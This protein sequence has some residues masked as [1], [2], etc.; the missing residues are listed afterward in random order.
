MRKSHRIAVSGALAAAFALAATPARG[1]TVSGTVVAPGGLPAAGARV[2]A[3]TAE[4][5]AETTTGRDGT[6]RLEIAGPP[7]LTIRVEAAGYPPAGKTVAEAE[8]S[9]LTIALSRPTV[10]E[11]ITV[12]A[13]R[14]P[15]PVADTAAP[16]TIVPREDLENTP[17]PAL[18][19][20]LRQVPGFSL[21]RRS[22]SRT[23]NPTSQG[24]S[25]RGLGASGTSRALV[26][27]DDIPM[28][29]P[30]G[31][32]VYWGRLPEIGLD[33]VEV[34]EGGGSDLWGSAALGGVIRLVRRD[35]AAPAVRAEAWGGSPSSADGSLRVAGAMGPLR[36]SA[37]AEVFAT[38]GYVAVAPEERGP[39]DVRAGS[40]HR[41]FEATAEATALG[42]SRLFVRASRYLEDR[43]N[44]TRLQRNDTEMTQWSGGF[45]GAAAGGA[46]ALRGY[47]SDERFHQTFSAISADRTSETRTSRQ[48]V[49][50][51]ATGGSAQWAR[52]I[53]T[54][55]ELV[56]GADFRE[57]EGTSEDTAFLPAGPALR[58]SGGRQRSGGAW[59]E[60]VAA[61][62]PRLTATA[63]LR[64]DAWSNLSGRTFEGGAPLALPDRSARSWSP[65]ASVVWAATRS[66]SLTAAG[67]RAFR[68][69]TLNELYRPFRLGNVQTLANADLAPE[70]V[71][72]VEAGA[73]WQ[74]L[75]GRLFA[76]ANLF[77][78]E[79]H[80]AVGNVTLAT[81][82][83]LITRRRENVGRVRDRGA[84]LAAD[85]R[86]SSAWSVSAGYLLAD[87][88]VAS[89]TTNPSLVGKRVP[90]VPRDQATLRVR[91][92]RPSLA[93]IVLQA[94]W[95]GRQYDDDAN[96]FRLGTAFT[97]DA[98]VSRELFG[99]G[100]IFAAVENLTDRRNEI[101]RTPVLTLGSPRTFRAGLRWRI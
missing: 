79:L 7:P 89:S 61:L 47:R 67:Y 90:Q 5:A 26:L 97:L 23:A 29:D 48:A 82:P 92:A 84:E 21:F 77:W 50:S 12:T 65:R 95:S 43:S 31:G 76:R 101:G 91:F 94:R 51:S 71:T 44:G 41:A 85:A 14:T 70:T 28:N 81:T 75:D 78:T 2:A 80:D 62:S 57:V 9:G 20:A 17:A 6:F 64:F 15:R 54:V 25:L 83:S 96:A 63:A 46:A 8:S 34:V 86:L 45:D 13:T 56:A 30:F 16:A 100:E 42:G 38:D 60:D 1:A 27:A 93:A 10:A 39:V 19:D 99:G 40:R 69:P 74:S 58:P 88:R 11:E 98:L 59:L 22:G 18:D 32:W 49:P 55:H 68:A 36:A 37:D 24:V 52:A 35:D 3:R 33:R 73:R 53:G 66:V 72:G 4:G 87:S